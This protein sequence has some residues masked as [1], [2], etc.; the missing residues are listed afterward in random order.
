[1][2][3]RTVSVYGHLVELE[4]RICAGGCGCKF[5]VTPDCGIIYARKNC[6]VVCK[7]APIPSLVEEAMESAKREILREHEEPKPLARRS[8]GTPNG[9]TTTGVPLRVING[10]ETTSQ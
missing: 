7:G 1:M 2:T 6:D 4:D 3:R 5:S 9:F 10:G 8:T